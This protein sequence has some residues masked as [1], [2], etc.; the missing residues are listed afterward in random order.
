M[1]KYLL[2]GIALIVGVLIGIFGG[3]SIGGGAMMGAGVA[4]GLTTGICTVIQ[5]AQDAGVMN[6]EQADQVMTQA[7]ASFLSE[8]SAEP[9]VGTAADCADFM[10]KLKAGK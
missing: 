1:G 6:T 10:K 2:A 3:A 4:T 5:A 8:G 9:A 7:A